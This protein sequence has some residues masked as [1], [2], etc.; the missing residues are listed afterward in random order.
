MAVKENS[1]YQNIKLLFTTI[2]HTIQSS[3]SYITLKE[4]M[5]FR[6]FKINNLD[7]GFTYLKFLVFRAVERFSIEPIEGS[8]CVCPCVCLL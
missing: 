4:P 1:I 7:H 5:W 2:K 6:I 8:T 3:L